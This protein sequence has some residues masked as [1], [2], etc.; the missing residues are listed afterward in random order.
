MFGI[1]K[2]TDSIS[3]NLHIATKKISPSNELVMMKL[4]TS[5]SHWKHEIKLT[6]TFE[7]N[8]KNKTS[9]ARKLYS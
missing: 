3:G 4:L 5:T 1:F 6:C 8:I 7:D 2:Y 9:E